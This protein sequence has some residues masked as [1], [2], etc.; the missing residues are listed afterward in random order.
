MN[1]LKSIRIEHEI[2]NIIYSYLEW[3][4]DIEK[5]TVEYNRLSEK[6]KIFE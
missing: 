4:T 6:E 2:E 5:Y 3:A 1:I